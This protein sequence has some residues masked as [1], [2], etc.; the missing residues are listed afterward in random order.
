MLNRSNNYVLI[1]GE[2]AIEDSNA[3]NLLKRVLKKGGWDEISGEAHHKTLLQSF[4]EGN[5]YVAERVVRSA[6]R[7]PLREMQVDCDALINV[8]KKFKKLTVPAFLELIIGE[9]QPSLAGRTETAT[10]V[11][12]EGAVGHSRPRQRRTAPPTNPTPPSP[13]I[14]MQTHLSVKDFCAAYSSF[15]VGGVRHFIFHEETNG[16]AASGAISRVGR[17]VLIHVEKFFAWVDSRKTET[18]PTPTRKRK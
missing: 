15:T 11:A 3:S 9:E 18:P 8:I 6:Q 13:P 2:L 14:P 7:I 10:P 4:Y 12:S 5:R 1:S 17:K 16:L